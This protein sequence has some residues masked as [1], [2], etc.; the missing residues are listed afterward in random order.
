MQYIRIVFLAVYLA[1]TACAQ[2][3]EARPLAEEQQLSFVQVTN[4][5]AFPNINV[6]AL[7]YSDHIS[8]I[9]ECFLLQGSSAPSQVVQSARAE[10]QSALVD[11]VAEF[12]AHNTWQLVGLR[13]GQ[14][15]WSSATGADGVFT[16]TG[17][18][19]LPLNAR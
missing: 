6:R 17:T 8:I 14:A 4:G 19:R 18:A 10:C 15:R 5:P 13:A 12:Q 11:A 16:L 3:Q 7:R 9:A 1:L 2:L